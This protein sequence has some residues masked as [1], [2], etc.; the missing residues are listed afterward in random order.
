[1][2]VAT[3]W[4]WMGIQNPV[5]S[6]IRFSQQ[7]L[8]FQVFGPFTVEFARLM[9]LVQVGALAIT[10]FLAYRAGAKG[11]VGSALENQVVVWAFLTA[12]LDLIVFNKVGSPQYYC[13]ILVPVIL[14]ILW[15]VPHRGLLAVS[16]ALVCLLTGLIFPIFYDQI[17]NQEILA[18][19]LL[20]LRNVLAIGLLVWSNVSL[21]RLGMK[22]LGK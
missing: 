19:S 2:P 8:T 11:S 12:I 20:T 21:S 5:E 4:L 18:T 10:V 16:A 9:D 3:P 7:L 13:W 6:G 15:Q 17:L 1:A 22:Q 14:A